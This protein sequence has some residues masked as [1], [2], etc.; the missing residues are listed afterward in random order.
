ML[1]HSSTH[2]RVRITCSSSLIRRG[3]RAGSLFT[4]LLWLSGGGVTPRRADRVARERQRLRPRRYGAMVSAVRRRSSTVSPNYWIGVAVQGRSANMLAS[5]LGG[6][7]LLGRPGGGHS[8]ILYVGCH[9]VVA[10]VLGMPL[11]RVKVDDA[12]GDM[13]YLGGRSPYR[14]STR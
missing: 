4:D 2:S 7:S 8:T 12:Q 9:P 1:S 3:R 5:I 10:D 14:S 11:A 6:L 13:Q